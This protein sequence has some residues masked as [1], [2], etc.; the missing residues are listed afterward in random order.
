MTTFHEQPQPATAK[1]IEDFLEQKR[2]AVVGVSRNPKEFS[3]QIFHEL[4]SLGYDTVAVNPHTDELDSR[5]CFPAVSKIDPP[6]DGV[7]VITSPK[8]VNEIVGDCLL[9]GVPRTWI[10][11]GSGTHSLDPELAKKCRASGMS[12]IEG[13]CP[14]MF[15]SGSGWFHR[16]H[17]WF[18]RHSKAYRT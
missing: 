2:L 17:G 14:Y 1:R 12:L 4:T 3:R 13:F 6:V 5:P 15:F 9:A 7:L 18:A 8:V 16:L 11:L 10:H